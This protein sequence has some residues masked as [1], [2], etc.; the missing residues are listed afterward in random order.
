MQ[1]LTSGQL[2]Q[3]VTRDVSHGILRQASAKSCMEKLMDLCLTVFPRQYITVIGCIQRPVEADT[4]CPVPPAVVGLTWFTDVGTTGIEGEGC[5]W[6][7][8]K[9]AICSLLQSRG[10]TFHIAIPYSAANLI[11]FF[12]LSC[13]RAAPQKIRQQLNSGSLSQLQLLL[14]CS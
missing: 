11:Q 10:C 13:K 5:R 8:R 6:V 4:I 9:A 3:A 1:Q 14:L 2:S 7:S 12:K